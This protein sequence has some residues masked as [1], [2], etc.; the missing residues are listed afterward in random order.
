MYV[1]I[2]D[3]HSVTKHVFTIQ[4]AK[5]LIGCINH[6]NAESFNCKPRCTK[7]LFWLH[8]FVVAER[9]HRVTFCHC[10]GENC[11]I[12]TE[13]SVRRNALNVSSGHPISVTGYHSR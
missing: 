6:N 12:G 3:N 13:I 1:Y 9:V 10:K 11:F 5:I 4:H 8:F 7:Q 2:M